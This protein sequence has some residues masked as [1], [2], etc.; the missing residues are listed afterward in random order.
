MRSPVG[1]VFLASRPVQASLLVP[2]PALEVSEEGV[3]RI[4]GPRA[5]LLPLPP[6]AWSIAILLGAP[7]TLPR[8]AEEAEASEGRAWSRVSFEVNIS[9]AP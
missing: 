7:S 9:P 8:T 4:A 3:V 5:Q 6:G 2:P 1:A